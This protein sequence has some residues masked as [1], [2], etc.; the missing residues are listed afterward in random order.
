MAAP[1]DERVGLVWLGKLVT[2]NPFKVKN[3]WSGLELIRFANTKSR[4]LLN[5]FNANDLRLVSFLIYI[6]KHY[7]CSWNQKT[8]R[9]WQRRYLQYYSQPP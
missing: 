4:S 2:N 8:S 7:I 6:K 3:A 9:I 5:S 1:A